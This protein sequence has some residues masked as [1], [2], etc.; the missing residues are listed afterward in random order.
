M[1]VGVINLDQFLVPAEAVEVKRTIEAQKAKRTQD[2]PEIIKKVTLSAIESGE[3]IAATK[4]N[5]P[6][7]TVRNWVEHYTSNKCEFYNPGKRG[8]KAKVN[9]AGRKEV[10]QVV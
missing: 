9:A 1:K 8:R 6:Y 5:V 10:L 2:T 7:T 4:H 3:T